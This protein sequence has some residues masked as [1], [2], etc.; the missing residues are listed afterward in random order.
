MI[1]ILNLCFPINILNYKSYIY[2]KEN[3]SNAHTYKQIYEIMGTGVETGMFFTVLPG[4]VLT[5]YFM[6]ALNSVQ[7][8][9]PRSLK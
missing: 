2:H 5:L 1:S 3:N 9:L 6:L 4:L 7:F 8:A